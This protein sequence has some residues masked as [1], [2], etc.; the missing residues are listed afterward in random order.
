MNAQHEAT[1][2]D[3]V[4]VLVISES[5]QPLEDDTLRLGLFVRLLDQEGKLIEEKVFEALESNTFLSSKPSFI[6]ALEPAQN[7]FSELFWSY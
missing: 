2:P 1:R 7:V 3:R 5:L 4:Q 6:R